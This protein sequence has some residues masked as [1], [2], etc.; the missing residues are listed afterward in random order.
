MMLRKKVIA[1]EKITFAGKFFIEKEVKN[2]IVL[3]SLQRVTRCNIY[4]MNYIRYMLKETR[5]QFARDRLTIKSQKTGDG[6]AS[7]ANDWQSKRARGNSSCPTPPQSMWTTKLHFPLWVKSPPC[8]KEG[9]SRRLTGGLFYSDNP[10]VKT[11]GF[12]SSLC[13][14]EPDRAA[15]H[16]A[17]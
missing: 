14:R 1:L 12:D 15:E 16:P 13:T 6:S 17:M 3:V 10:S 5:G 4:L 2:I 7:S 8:V 11:D 9:G